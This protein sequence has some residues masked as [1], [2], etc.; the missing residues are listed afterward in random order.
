MKLHARVQSAQQTQQ[1]LPVVLIHGLFG[2]LDNLGVLARDLV[3]DH[4]VM[5]VDLRNHGLSPRSPDMHWAALAGDI[6]DTM[7]SAGFERAILIGHSMGG[8]TAMA[9]T[10][11]AP[12]RIDKLVA[13]DI[14]PVDYHLRRHDDI[15]AAIRAVS[16]AGVTTRHDAAAIMREHIK[17]EG[18]IQFI[19]KSFVQGEWR[20]NVPVLWDAYASIVGWDDVPAWPHPAMF[21]C[22]GDSPYVKPEYRPAIL[23]Q[24]PQAQAHV[25]AGTGHW[26]HAEKPDA[27]LRVIRQFLAAGQESA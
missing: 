24:F 1:N 17:E 15:F 26:V 9:T 10:A 14:S 11:L 18:V 23:R 13:I 16:A 25:I 7:D 20:F 27:V 22:G 3:N 19:L 6:L 21:I 12:E 8:K 5:Q 2:S 4:T